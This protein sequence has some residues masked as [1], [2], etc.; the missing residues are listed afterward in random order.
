VKPVAT[1]GDRW[2][3]RA[4]D[5]EIAR[6]RRQMRRPEVEAALARI[7][8]QIRASLER[9]FASSVDFTAISR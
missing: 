1:Q 2:K 9:S 5:D 7:H 8:E 3:R 6:R 4:L